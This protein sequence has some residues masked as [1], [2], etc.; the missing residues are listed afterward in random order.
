[1]PQLVGDHRGRAPG[2]TT[3][4]TGFLGKQGSS[5]TYGCTNAI[6]SLGGLKVPNFFALV[7]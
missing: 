5:G 3:A 6:A 7:M 4:N 1:M 2:R